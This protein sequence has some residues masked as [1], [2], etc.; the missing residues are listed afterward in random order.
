[1]KFD[2]ENC[3]KSACQGIDLINKKFPDFEIDK[4]KDKKMLILA[5]KVYGGLLQFIA[6]H[7]TEFPKDRLELF[8]EFSVKYSE[9]TISL[10][11]QGIV[12]RIDESI[13]YDWLKKDN[14]LKI[15]KKI[16]RSIGKLGVWITS[17]EMV[18][19]KVMESK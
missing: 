8:G 13:F 18:K 12:Y 19:I 16:K 7:I 3:L 4:E 5:L 11:I 17:D 2:L 15:F 14:Y 9:L 6:I 1:M 10:V